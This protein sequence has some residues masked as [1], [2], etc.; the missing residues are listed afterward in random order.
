MLGLVVL[1][2]CGLVVV[3]GL[4]VVLYFGWVCCNIVSGCG[5]L[6]WLFGVSLRRWVCLGL[7][8]IGFLIGWSCGFVGCCAMR[9]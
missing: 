4:A 2:G 6:V 7:R 3:W 9:A 5:G 8:A 1:C